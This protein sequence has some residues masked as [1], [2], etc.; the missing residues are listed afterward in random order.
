MIERG[1]V[2]R[3]RVVP[4]TELVRRLPG[5]GWSWERLEH[6][7][8]LKKRPAGRIVDLSTWHW[9]AGPIRT[10]E[11]AARETWAKMSARKRDD[12]S[13]MSVSIHL[14][15]GWDGVP[16]QLADL[17]LATIHA[18]RAI[19][20]RAVGTELTWPGTA[21]NAKAIAATLERHKRPVHAGYHGVP[22]TRLARGRRLVCLPP[23][24]ELV[25]GAVA[26]AE[27]LSALPPELGI[28]IPRQLAATAGAT[29]TPKRRGAHEHQHVRGTEKVDCAGY[30]VEALE[31]AGWVTAPR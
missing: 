6:R 7:P 30:I 22:E 8:D 24:R 1:L 14:V 17:G 31:A 3:G 23:S 26:L 12:G 10:G 16:W 5:V 13:D 28:V 18:G 15:V 21:S 27:L 2:V 29:V 25:G 19:D 20:P 9:T 11:D 4:G